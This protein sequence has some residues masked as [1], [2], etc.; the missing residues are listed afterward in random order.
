MN[1]VAKEYVGT[2]IHN[3]RYKK[4]ILINYNCSSTSVAAQYSNIIS[5]APFRQSTTIF[6][7]LAHTYLL[8]LS[9][10]SRSNG[11]AENPITIVR[12]FEFRF[13]KKL[14]Q[15]Y[16]IRRLKDACSGS[17]LVLS[18]VAKQNLLNLK[19]PQYGNTF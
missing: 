3:N 7:I 14:H 6:G 9:T 10:S 4:C 8:T 18:R 16:S 17:L 19:L 5:V 15:S 11:F 1:T 2:D 12:K 13:T